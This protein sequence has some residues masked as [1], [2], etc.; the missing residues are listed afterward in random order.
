MHA[1]IKRTTQTLSDLIRLLCLAPRGRV[2]R[3]LPG[4]AHADVFQDPGA[5][6]GVFSVFESIRR[7]HDPA[8]VPRVRLGLL[9]SMPRYV[10]VAMRTCSHTT[11]ASFGMRHKLISRRNSP[12]K[13][14]HATR[15]NSM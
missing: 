15:N 7:P 12:P 4:Q 3:A 14:R 5:L 11:L 6:L 8:R 10:R 2:G 1:P 9:R 13:K